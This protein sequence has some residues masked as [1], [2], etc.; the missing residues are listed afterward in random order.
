MPWASSGVHL[1]GDPLRLQRGGRA[2]GG[3][4]H[5]RGRIQF[6]EEQALFE[7]E[8]QCVTMLRPRF[9]PSAECDEKPRTASGKGFALPWSV[10]RY[11]PR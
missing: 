6:A 9:L 3:G 5:Q 10:T 2:I 1:C 4:Q 7:L 8:L 11:R